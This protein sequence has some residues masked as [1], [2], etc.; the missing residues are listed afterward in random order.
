[1]EVNLMAGLVNLSFRTNSAVDAIVEQAKK[2]AQKAGGRAL[3][4]EVGGV[5][6]DFLGELDKAS[7]E[8]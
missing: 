3:V 6:K 2:F 5:T 8:S 7:E 4:V 1:M